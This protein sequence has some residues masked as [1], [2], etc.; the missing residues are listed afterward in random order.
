MTMILGT[1]EKIISIFA[2]AK[3]E[4]MVKSDRQTNNNNI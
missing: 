4:K 1:E 2:V 3:S